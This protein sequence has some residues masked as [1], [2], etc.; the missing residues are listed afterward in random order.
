M[1]MLSYKDNM[2]MAYEHKIPNYMPLMSD[3]DK[4]NI[5]GLDFV[6]ERP[7]VP[8]VHDDWYGQS[9]TFVDS[10][11]AASPTPGKYLL[12]EIHEWREKIKFPN[13]DKLDW[14]G[15]SKRDT[16][17]WSPE[18]MHSVRIFFGMWERLNS[19]L[20]FSKSLMAL[21]EDP[22]ECY[23]FFGAIAGFKIKL[24]D[25]IIDYYKP[26]ILIMHDDYGTQDRMFMSPKAW[27]E[28][29]KPHLKRVCDAVHSRGVIYEHHSCGY[30]AP[31]IPD[32][33]EL[34]IDAVDYIQI[35]NPLEDILKKYNK[36]I[37]L[38]GCLDNQLIDSE[39]TTEETAR[40]HVREMMDRLASYGSFIPAPL[41]LGKHAKAV[42]DEL[43]KHSISFYKTRR[44]DYK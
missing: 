26:D 13:L 21:I 1:E 17:N 36:N 28:L 30:I 35:V 6:N 8:G 32:M 5:H 18:K 38:V 44:P 14:E 4:V 34:G 16:A 33:I 20:D 41:V 23:D 31:I 11:H 39:L 25:K 15:Y 27:R 3:I 40:S 10:I 43:L 29:L 22:E 12:N 19:I 2:K 24:H 7:E 42:S 37:T 9:W